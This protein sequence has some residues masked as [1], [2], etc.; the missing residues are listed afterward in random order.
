MGELGDRHSSPEPRVFLYSM[1]FLTQISALFARIAYDLHTLFLFTKSDARTILFPL[2]SRVT[3]VLRK[4]IMRRYLLPTF[5]SLDFHSSGVGP[6]Q[7]VLPFAAHR[8]V[9]VASSTARRSI[10]PDYGS[11]RRSG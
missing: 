5:M 3:F 2:V 10:E 6:T 7:F 4:L 1:S 11:R 8:M 9:A